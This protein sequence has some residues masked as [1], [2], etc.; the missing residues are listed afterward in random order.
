LFHSQK[1]RRSD[2]VMF[3]SPNTGMVLAATF[4]AQAAG[5]AA[6]VNPALS[7]DRIVTLA[8]TAQAAIIVAGGPELDPDLWA[9][10]RQVAEAVHARALYA[11]R[12]DGDRSE[13]PELEPVTGTVTAYLDAAL[14]EHPDDHLRCSSPVAGDIA[15][16]FHT[17]GT[18]GAPKLAAH[19][20][21]NEVVMA[22]S[23]ALLSPLTEGSAVLA[24]LPLFHV[25]AV[26]VTGLAPLFR[27]HPVLW[28]GP[29][30]FRDVT[31][32]QNFWKIV[33]HHRVAAMS[34]VPTV[35]AVL[36]EIPV[37]ADIS[38]LEFAAV[39]AAPLPESVRI[40]FQ[41][42]T[43]VVLSEGYG[44]TEATCVSAASPAHAARPGSVGL[45][46]PYQRVV[47]VASDDDGT[48]DE[49]PAGHSGQLA[50]GGPTVFPGYVNGDGQISADQAVHNGMLLTGDLGYVSPDGYVYLNGRIKDVIIRGGHN[51]DPAIIEDA[52]R[53]HPAVSDAAA[54]GRPD[55]HSGE[56]PIVYVVSD[57]AVGDAELLTWAS[58]TISEPAA[59]PKEVH[60]VAAIPMTSIGKPFKPALRADAASRAVLK[61]LSQ[62]GLRLEAATV[63]AEHDDTGRLQV[64]I[65]GLDTSEANHARSLLRRLPLTITF[66]EHADTAR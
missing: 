27:G 28:T 12:P 57:R 65:R 43:G 47:A 48:W 42:R 36:A 23:L 59:I 11:I 45:R 46:L 61:L 37:D 52:M 14:A 39:G 29:N 2:A 7:L 56:V 31:L 30:G 4:G 63:T 22:W 3:L 26:H 6:P 9:R 1:I 32:Y 17:G 5:I 38:T 10:A 41:Q 18:T 62:N 19:T 58:N 44:L 64:Q 20:H 50:I 51:I 34:A 33:E 24:G 16:Y 49:L 8:K 15:S 60:R 55:P 54:V 66:G 35:Y 53:R 21:R 25:N 13:G 40:S